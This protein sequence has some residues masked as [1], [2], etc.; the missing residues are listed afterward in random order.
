MN[1]YRTLI[2]WYRIVGTVRNPFAV[3]QYHFTYKTL[4]T[5]KVSLLDA[6]EKTVKIGTALN[7]RGLH[8]I[9]KPVALYHVLNCFR[10]GPV[11]FRLLQNRY[12]IL[13]TV[14]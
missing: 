14:L 12:L 6:L 3:Q 7:T 1:W 10:Y 5:P 9:I 4:T 2:Y 8:W 13:Y 11:L